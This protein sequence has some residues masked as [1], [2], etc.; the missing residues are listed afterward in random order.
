[1][2]KIRFYNIIATMLR[3]NHQIKLR[4][5]RRRGY[6]DVV[7]IDADMSDP[8]KSGARMYLDKIGASPQRMPMPIPSL[9][10]HAGPEPSTI[11]A[12]EH[13]GKHL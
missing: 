5:V 11:A 13:P 8:P 12:K 1:M 2:S 9:T 6:A 10:H 3:F 7:T 4:F